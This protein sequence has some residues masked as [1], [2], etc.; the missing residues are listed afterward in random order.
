MCV[1]Q[2]HGQ[3]CVER[4]FER[5]ARE[6]VCRDALTASSSATAPSRA[7]IDAARPPRVS[8]RVP[9]PARGSWHV[10]HI[11]NPRGTTNERVA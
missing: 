1:V 11:H 2:G 5:R 8:V 4:E 6:S 7:E 10:P 9:S 3:E